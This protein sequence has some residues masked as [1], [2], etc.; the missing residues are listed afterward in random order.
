MISGL[1]MKTENHG[2]TDVAEAIE[3]YGTTL[4]REMGRMNGRAMG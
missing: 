2:Y 4:G 3:M 1:S